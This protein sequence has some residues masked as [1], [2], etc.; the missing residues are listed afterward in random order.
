M[1]AHNRPT[2]GKEEANAAARVIASAWVAQGSEVERFENELCAFLGLPPGHA[3]AVSSGSAALYLALWVLNVKGQTVACPVYGS[4]TVHNAIGLAGACPHFLDIALSGPNVDPIALARCDA[5]VAIVPH[6]FGLPV[7][8]EGIAGLR[9]VEDCAQ[10][11]GARVNG[12]PVGLQGD[13]GIYSF[14]ATKLITSGGQ[15]GMLVS[16]D[17]GL[18]DEVRD[19]R[20]YDGHDDRK[21]RFN[22]Q[23]TDL[24]AAIGR[25][26]LSKLPKFLQR[27]AEVY[28]YYRNA[29]LGLMDVGPPAEPVRY[30]AV[31]ETDEPVKLLTRLNSCGI[32][33]IVP[34]E[35]WE[36]LDL[37]DRYQNALSLTRHTVSLPMHPS[38]SNANL[39]NVIL[40]VQG[41]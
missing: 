41:H 18:V 3:V 15:G 33:A 26:Q 39:D 6:M 29:G 28:A 35:D 24:Q 16:R 9:L 30:R 31:M 7:N 36:L 12:V 4:C 2:L 22:F 17:K 40:V 8:L 38:L 34:V 14:Q 27:R 32:K 1:I 11:L 23:M 21:L 37:P 13:I 20:N 10:A 25:V 5:Q 19:C